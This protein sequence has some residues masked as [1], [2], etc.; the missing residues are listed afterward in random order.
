MNMESPVTQLDILKEA[1]YKIDA[2]EGRL[3]LLKVKVV[4]SEN[5]DWSMDNIIK[6]NNIIDMIVSTIDQMRFESVTHE[7][8]KALY[9]EAVGYISQLPDIDDLQEKVKEIIF[10]EKFEEK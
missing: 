3:A 4:I 10:D 9:E 7:A 6:Y 1:I 2:R 5:H 8:K